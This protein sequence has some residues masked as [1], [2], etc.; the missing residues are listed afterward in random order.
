MVKPKV[1][2]RSPSQPI[3]GTW[4]DQEINICNYE[5]LRYLGT[6]T[7]QFVVPM[8][9]NIDTQETDAT[10]LFKAAIPHLHVKT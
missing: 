6:L 1:I 7:L 8:S 4:S 10:K 3:I 5:V 2:G 9:P